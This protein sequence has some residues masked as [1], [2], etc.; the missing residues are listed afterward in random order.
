MELWV[1]SCHAP[2]PSWGTLKIMKRASDTTKLTRRNKQSVTLIID[3][4]GT[5]LNLHVNISTK[6]YEM[7]ACSTSQNICLSKL[8][9]ETEKKF[10][11]DICWVCLRLEVGKTFFMPLVTVPLLPRHSWFESVQYSQVNFLLPYM[12]WHGSISLL[13][14]WNPSMIKW[15]PPLSGAC[16]SLAVAGWLCGKYSAGSGDA[17]TDKT[18]PGLM[19]QDSTRWNPWQSIYALLTSGKDKQSQAQC[20][21]LSLPFRLF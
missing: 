8:H 16:C 18:F 15:M 14:K 19:V 9:T 5:E 6:S 7:L 13:L 11:T 4:N 1:W 2:N 12:Q 20:F 10:T 21:S 17:Q 3:D